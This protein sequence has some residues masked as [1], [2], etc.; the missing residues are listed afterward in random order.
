MPSSQVPRPPIRSKPKS[1]TSAQPAPAPSSPLSFDLNLLGI[2]LAGPSTQP[3]SSSVQSSPIRPASDPPNPFVD[4]KALSLAPPTYASMSEAAP[5]RSSL[6]QPQPEPSPMH[7]LPGSDPVLE[8]LLTSQDIFSSY[9]C[10]TLD[11][12]F[13]ASQ[14]AFDLAGF[15]EL[16]FALGAGEFDLDEMF[17]WGNVIGDGELRKW[18]GGWEGIDN[19][20]ATGL[21][22]GSGEFELSEGLGGN[23]G[24]GLGPDGAGIDLAVGVGVGADTAVNFATR[25]GVPAV[26]PTPGRLQSIITG[27][28]SGTSGPADLNGAGPGSDGLSL[29]DPQTFQTSNYANY[30]Q[31]LQLLPSQME[32]QSLWEVPIEDSSFSLSDYVDYTMC[33]TPSVAGPSRGTSLGPSRPLSRAASVSASGTGRG[34]SLSSSVPPGTTPSHGRSVGSTRGR[35][36]TRSAAGSSSRAT[37]RISCADSR[38]SAGRRMGDMSM[39]YFPGISS[40]PTANQGLSGGL[41]LG[42]DLSE[43]QVDP[44]PPTLPPPGAIIGVGPMSGTDMG[45]G[46]AGLSMAS[47]PVLSQMFGSAEVIRGMDAEMLT[48]FGGMLPGSSTTQ[49]TRVQLSQLDFIEPPTAPTIPS[50]IPPSTEVQPQLTHVQSMPPPGVLTVSSEDL[51][52]IAG[53][54]AIAWDPSQPPPAGYLLVAVPIPNSINPATTSSNLTPGTALSATGT[55]HSL[56]CGSGMEL[57]NGAMPGMILPASTIDPWNINPIDYPGGA[58]R[59]NGSERDQHVQSQAEGV[60]GRWMGF[61]T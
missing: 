5:L 7:P 18:G 43:M 45:I 6:L 14:E 58:I 32:V 47:Q 2:P 54:G 33:R 48:A 57:P 55:I 37:S 61:G 10:D 46:G 28:S 44:P 13:P 60:Q 19:T 50:S 42:L 27:T 22:L 11:L 30:A 8:S 52:G 17:D 1:Q 23:E 15:D 40:G 35:S 21:D 4:P 34:R 3:Q 12:P 9:S 24:R 39:N 20:Y 41:G 38:E 56:S 49:P 31:Q 16:N 59:P 51:A 29:P 53:Q 36:L 25:I 26:L